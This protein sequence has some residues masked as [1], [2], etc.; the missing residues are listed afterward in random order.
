M[1][2]RIVVGVDCCEGGRDALTLAMQLQSAGGGELVAVHACAPGPLLRG[3]VLT[4]VEAQMAR[5]GATG[6][7][8]AVA[9]RSPAHTL[10]MAAEREGAELIVIGS[11]HLAGAER[12]LAGDDTAATLHGAPGAV[13]VAVAPRGFARMPGTLRRIGVGLDGSKKSSVALALAC[14]LAHQTGARVRATTVVPVRMARWP[15]P[16]LDPEWS[17][18]DEAARRAGRA[19]AHR[20][21]RE[22]STSTS[23]PRSWSARRGR[24]SPRAARTS[25]S[26]SW[27]P[28]RADPCAGCSSGARRRSSRVTPRVRCWW[29]PQGD[30][31]REPRTATRMRAARPATVTPLRDAHELG[32]RSPCPHRR[33]RSQARLTGVGA[34]CCGARL[35]PSWTQ[36][37]EANA[38]QAGY[39]L[40][41]GAEARTVEGLY[42]DVPRPERLR[43]ALGRGRS[44]PRQE[45]LVGVVAG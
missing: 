23:R 12:I 27:A 44:A 22:G 2:T 17:G 4:R 14:R 29:R 7:A 24:S 3:D 13:A 45:F 1:F 16:A 15:K 11:S 42:R 9:D 36:R 30:T 43:D 26:S 41:I 40:D 31:A 32:T 19:A 38:P 20:R 34:R 10:R 35:G 8:Q 37:D 18:H 6:R 28:A 21:R 39:R 25:T 5:V 33:A